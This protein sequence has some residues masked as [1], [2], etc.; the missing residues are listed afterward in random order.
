MLAANIWTEQGVSNAGVKD[1]TEG[2]E[3]FQA[4]LREQQCQPAISPIA[5]GDWT[6]N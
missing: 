6:T 5:P 3:G 1:V 2:A 4:P